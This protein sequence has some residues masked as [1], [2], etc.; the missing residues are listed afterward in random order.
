M[1]LILYSFLAFAAAFRGW[2]VWP[3]G[4][5][6]LPFAPLVAHASSG[7]DILSYSVVGSPLSW[8]ALVGLVFM[9]VVGRN[10]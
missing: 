6:A 7:G 3:F 4:L 8:I 1:E 2:G 9:I 5:V 10:R